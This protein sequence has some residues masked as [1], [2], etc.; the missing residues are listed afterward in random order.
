MFLWRFKT[1]FFSSKMPNLPSV[2]FRVLVITN[3]GLDPDAG[4][5]PD[6]D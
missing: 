5:V 2:N 3:L 4:S 6:P 1:N